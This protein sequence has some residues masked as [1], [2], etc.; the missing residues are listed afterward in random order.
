MVLISLGD[1]YIY[2]CMDYNYLHSLVFFKQGGMAF[3]LNSYFTMSFLFTSYTV[4][5]ICVIFLSA[6]PAV[7]IALALQPRDW[8]IFISVLCISEALSI[9]RLKSA[10]SWKWEGWVWWCQLMAF[11]KDTQ[12]LSTSLTSHCAPTLPNMTFWNAV[13]HFHV[14]NRSVQA[15]GF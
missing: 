13:Y 5:N 11:P 14:D 6:C 3:L 2:N 12:S 15:Q 9:I 8:D 7:P 1:L 10:L 4:L